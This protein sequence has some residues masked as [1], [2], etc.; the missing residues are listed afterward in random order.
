M[1]NK[2]KIVVAV[3]SLAA[4]ATLTIGGTLAYFTSE[5][6]AKNVVTMGK[7]AIDL[8]E[9]SV[10]GEETGEGFEYK[11]VMPG[12]ELDKDVN[13]KVLDGS[14]D[15]YIA[16]KVEVKSANIA[17]DKLK[18]IEFNVDECWKLE[19]QVGNTFFYVYTKNDELSRVAA[20]ADLDVFNTVK[21]PGEDWTNSEA[22]ET[23]SIEVTAYAIQAEN[24]AEVAIVELK[25]MAG[26]AE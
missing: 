13:V 23:F 15:A 17:V 10:D 16:V 14:Q 9:T 1:K 20:N 25:K 19:K 11:N 7:V 8:V 12:D 22:S 3:A 24:T 2:K 6:S 26:L 21:I 4:V 18:K 5:D